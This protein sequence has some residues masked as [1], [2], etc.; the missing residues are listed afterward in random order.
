MDAGTY[1]KPCIKLFLFQCNKFS[2][3]HV[4]LHGKWTIIDIYGQGVLYYNRGSKQ[5]QCFN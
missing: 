4:P 2:Y 3:N 1:R 5:T